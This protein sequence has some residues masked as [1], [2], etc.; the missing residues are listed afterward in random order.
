L[1]TSRR[2]HERYQTDIVVTVTFGETTLETR[3]DNISLGGMH[4]LAEAQPPFSE[5]VD[6]R[7][8]LPNMK[9]DT[10]CKGTVRWNRPE[11]FGVSFD[12][13]RALDTWGLNQFF[14]Q[15]AKLA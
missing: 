11:G 9:E 2:G 8:R 5:V 10:V 15:L 1:T 4:L 7:F 12:G 14:K 6:L 3:T 13:M